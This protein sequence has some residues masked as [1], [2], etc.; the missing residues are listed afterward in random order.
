MRVKFF[1]KNNYTVIYLFTNISTR[2]QIKNTYIFCC[3]I[4]WGNSF[5]LKNP[6]CIAINLNTKSSISIFLFCLLS[7]N[8]SETVCRGR[9]NSLKCMGFN[10]VSKDR[11]LIFSCVEHW[12]LHLILCKTN[13]TRC[14][15]FSHFFHSINLSK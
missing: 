14:K 9:G 11:S 3:S 6:K 1:V 13:N 15:I 10:F 7:V 8:S 5:C 4:P 2:C 12:A